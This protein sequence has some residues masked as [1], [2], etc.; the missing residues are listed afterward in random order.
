MDIVSPYNMSSCHTSLPKLV[1]AQVMTYIYHVP[2]L[3][4]MFSMHF[5]FPSYS[6]KKSEYKFEQLS[7]NVCNFLKDGKKNVQL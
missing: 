7:W 6:K 2:T 1:T 3:F 4:I 5:P